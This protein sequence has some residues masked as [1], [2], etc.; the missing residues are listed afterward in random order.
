M[1]RIKERDGRIEQLQDKI[2]NSGENNAVEIK[3][4]HESLHKIES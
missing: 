4:L 3:N 1:D 2:K